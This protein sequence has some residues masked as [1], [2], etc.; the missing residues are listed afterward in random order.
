MAAFNRNPPACHWLLIIP[1]ETFANYQQAGVCIL[2]VTFPSAARLPLLLVHIQASSSA[3]GAL[4]KVGLAGWAPEGLVPSGDGPG[5]GWK[6]APFSCALLPGTSL[7]V[8]G[9]GW[10]LWKCL[11]S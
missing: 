6:I 4:G 7:P 10:L 11:E 1:L 2:G 8:F 9:E 5:G 3:W